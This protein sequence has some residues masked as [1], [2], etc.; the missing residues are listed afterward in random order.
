[1]FKTKTIVIEKC[2][3]NSVLEDIGANTLE[4]G[5]IGNVSCLLAD[6]LNDF[7][8][9]RKYIAEFIHDNNEYLN[10]DDIELILDDPDYIINLASLKFYNALVELFNGDSDHALYCLINSNKKFDAWGNYF[11]YVDSDIAMQYII[12]ADNESEAYDM[13]I[14]EFEKSFII[15]E[16]DLP[17]IEDDI[18]YNENGNPCKTDYLRLIGIICPNN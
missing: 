1:M 3:L 17:E 6:Y 8:F 18:V 11:I 5:F 16:D 10:S 12:R 2:G 13:L 15:D 14:T 4:N 7:T 9:S